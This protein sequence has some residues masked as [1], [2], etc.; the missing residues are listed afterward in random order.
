MKVSENGQFKKLV[1]SA[2]LISLIITPNLNK[3]SMVIPKAILLFL[4]ALFFLPEVLR[5][6]KIAVKQPYIGRLFYLS[7][8]LLIFSVAIIIN[9]EAPLEQLLFGRS[10]RGL[11]FITFFSLIIIMLAASIFMSFK[12]LRII[13]IGLVSSGFLT[14]I[15]SICQFFGIDFF[16]WDTRTNGIVGTLGN[17]NFQSSFAAMIFLPSIVFFWSLKYKYF[18]I[19]ITTFLIFATIYV[20][21]STQGYIGLTTAILIFLIL[22]FSYRNKLISLFISLLTFCGGVVA[23][24]GMLGHGPLS[25][26]LYKISIQSRG[27]FWRSALTTGNSH[28]FLGVGFDSFGDYSLRY[29]DQI[30]ASH[31]FAEYTDSAHNYYLDYLATGGYPFLIL[32][33]LLFLLVLRSFYFIY[34]KSNLFDMNISALFCAWTVFQLQSII[35][36]GG[37]PFMVWNSII[38]GSVIALASLSNNTEN[39]SLYSRAVLKQKLDLSKVFVIII[40]LVISFPIF[41]TDRMQLKAIQTGNGDLLI[42]TVTSYPESVLKY[43]QASRDLLTSGLAEPSLFVA[44][45]GVEFNPN[46]PAMWALI[47]MN[48]TAS[49]EE[50]ARAKIKVLEL[51][52]LNKEVKNLIIQ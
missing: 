21:N 46:S 5:S 42:K 10:G 38:S 25:F 16:E 37:I 13:M 6:S 47:L 3:D 52:P 11:G 24:F 34:K 32:N 33:I 29:R 17:P 48:P 40:G 49:I 44:R 36:P 14:S 9:S 4:T 45:K 27:D 8:S 39:T 26:Y 7:L 15:Y 43:S 51:D 30:A 31:N 22:F 50:R 35:S 28:P 18:L 20:S 2:F 23:I 19:F 1:L 12:N 41:N